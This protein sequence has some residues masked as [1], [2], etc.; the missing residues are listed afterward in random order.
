V[1]AVTAENVES[2]FLMVEDA[3]TINT[4]AEAAGVP[5]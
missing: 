5:P 1:R 4:M 2:G 3:R